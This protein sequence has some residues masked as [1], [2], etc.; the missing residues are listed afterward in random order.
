MYFI[1]PF[2]KTKWNKIRQFYNLTYPAVSLFKFLIN[3]MLVC[4]Y[5]SIVLIWVFQLIFIGSLILWMLFLRTLMWGTLRDSVIS[6]LFCCL[7]DSFIHY[8]LNLQVIKNCWQSLDRKGLHSS[9]IHYLLL[10]FLSLFSKIIFLCKLWVIHSPV[11]ITH[12][13]TVFHITFNDKFTNET[14]D[15]NKNVKKIYM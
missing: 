10:F 6:Y 7:A 12:L 14:L 3:I 5:I 11:S 8:S 9:R 2:S 15:H 1:C 13:I 4:F